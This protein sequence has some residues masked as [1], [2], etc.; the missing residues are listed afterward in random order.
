[1]YSLSEATFTLTQPKSS[2]THGMGIFL[3]YGVKGKKS[4]IILPGSE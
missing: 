1:M 3:A 4:L 2:P